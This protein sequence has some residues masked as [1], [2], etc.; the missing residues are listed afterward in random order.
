MSFRNTVARLGAVLALSLCVA[1]VS[2]A[3][4]PAPA[5]DA[6]D[7]VLSKESVLRD[8]EIPAFGNP[9]GD[10]TVVEYFDYQC[11]YCKK[12]SPVLAQLMKDDGRVRVVFKDWPILG[13]PSGYA[14]RLTLAAKFQNKYEVAHETLMARTGRLTE[15]GIDFALSEAG[16]DVTKAKADLE[17]NKPAIDG[18]P[19][20][21]Q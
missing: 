7:N 15:A 1:A 16:V 2:A 5:S 9:N 20:A 19:E 8:P 14:A 3:P 4:A 10:I 18:I 12:V 11:P 6:A 13:D 21:K 17:A